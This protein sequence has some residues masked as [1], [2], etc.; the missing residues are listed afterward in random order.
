MQN[1]C[2]ETW[3]ILF[4]YEDK[5]YQL[6]SILNQQLSNLND[7]CQEDEISYVYQHFQTML[8]NIRQQKTWCNYLK[9]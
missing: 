4:Q 8:D 5:L 2:N 9:G 1:L 6:E 3:R 7:T